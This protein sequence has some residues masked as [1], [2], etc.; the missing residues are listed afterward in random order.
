MPLSPVDRGADDSGS[1][2]ERLAARAAFA[3]SDL[4]RL[5]CNGMSRSEVHEVR[6]VQCVWV[7]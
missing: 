4:R 6:A 2:P 7:G 5:A 1:S 3:F